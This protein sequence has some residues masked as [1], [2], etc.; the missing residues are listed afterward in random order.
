MRGMPV[1]NEERRTVAK[2]IRFAPSELERVL[3]QAKASGRPVASSHDRA[4]ALIQRPRTL[5]CHP[6]EASDPG[7][8]RLRPGRRGGNMNEKVNVAVIYYSATGNVYQLARAIGEGA[9]Q[10]GGEVRLR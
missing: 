7:L 9:E 1:I 5:R 6:S 8:A 10:A 4:R 2:L 3:D